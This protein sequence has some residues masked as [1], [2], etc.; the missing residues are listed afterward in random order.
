METWLLP[1][2]IV[3]TT[4]G[5]GL[6]W[7]IWQR[8]VFFAVFFSMML[9]YS[10]VAQWGYF[11]YP[12][13]SEVVIRMYFGNAA[14]ASATLFSTLSLCAMYVGYRVIYRP[15]T[16]TPSF[17]MRPMRKQPGVF[18]F[19]YAVFVVAF[20][21]FYLPLAG[22]LDYSNASDEAF[23]ASAGVG[24][25]LF[26][27]FYKLSVFMLLVAWAA[28]R[29]RLFRARHDRV[30]AQ[31]LFVV[32]FGMFVTA[33]LA[34]GSRTDPL[35]L[36]LGLF[37]FEYFWRRSPLRH[38]SPSGDA[39]A[40]AGTRR[41]LPWL[42]IMLLGAIFVYLLTLLEF[43]R[44]PE[45]SVREDVA[46][47]AL[48]QAILLKDYYTPFHV[49]VGAMANGY[50]DPLTALRSNLANS[51]MFFNV[52]YLQYFVV[53]RWDPGLVTRTASPAMFAFTEG[54][55]VLGWAGLAYNGVIWAAGITLWR[56]LSRTTDDRF[57][58]LAFA[59][60]LALAATVARS[61][62]SYFI[63]DI[64]LFFIPAL[65]LYCVLA[66]CRPSLRRLQR[67]RQRRPARQ[68]EPA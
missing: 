11:L 47:S 38:P 40:T 16:R 53:E 60:A 52:D 39:V 14:L 20:A 37:G 6:T 67:V 68:A 24:Y 2:L 54:Y 5:L 10:V 59:L 26:W 23:L 50:I 35:A 3:C 15:L 33:T 43:S 4:V 49:L 64:Y 9:L 1:L 41:K 7:R 31:S 44:N 18:I 32:H 19:V 58:A 42:R 45:A 66:G 63:K 56:M 27:Q 22:Q 55:V 25:P 30:V 61:Q 13:L 62:S 65:A 34:V 12:E 29:Q 46:A 8:D 17:R 51:L 48:A 57:N 21:A 28:H 36:A